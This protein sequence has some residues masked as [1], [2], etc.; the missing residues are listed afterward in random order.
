[1]NIS[2]PEPL[3]Q[4]VERQIESGRY[5]S[6]SEYVRELIRDDERRRAEERLEASLLQ[7][8]ESPASEWTQ[9]DVT[10]IKKAVRERLAA[11]RTTA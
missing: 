7:G 2:L 6:V 10:Q 3:K 9:E 4:F 1:M 5:S 11:K 8:L